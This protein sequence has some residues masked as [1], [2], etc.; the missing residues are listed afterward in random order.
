MMRST[1]TAKQHNMSMEVD[2]LVEKTSQGFE[3]SP[4]TSEPL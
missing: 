2:H 3:K 4:A 1:S